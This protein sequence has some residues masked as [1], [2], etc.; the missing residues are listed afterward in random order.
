MGIKILTIVKTPLKVGFLYI[1]VVNLFFSRHILTSRNE[2][3]LLCSSSKV[4]LI[5]GCFVFIYVYIPQ[6]FS[7]AH[8]S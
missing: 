3:V 4:N 2:K 7:I 1:E 6:T 8:E 5:F